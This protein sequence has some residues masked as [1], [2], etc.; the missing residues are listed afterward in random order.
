MKVTKRD[1]VKYIYEKIK[2]ENPDLNLE[3]DDIK[4]SVNTLIDIIKDYV[5]ENN[6][7][8]IR[9]FGTFIPKYRKKRIARIPK[10]GGEEII[11]EERYVPVIKFSSIFKDELNKSLINEN[12]K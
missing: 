11:L 2:K 5:A 12:E 7:I 10:K 1:I 9:Y 6:T 3:L 8:E 4:Y